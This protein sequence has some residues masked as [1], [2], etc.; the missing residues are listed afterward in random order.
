[1]LRRQRLDARDPRVQ[2]ARLRLLFRLVQPRLD[3]PRYPPLGRQK[4]DL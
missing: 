4:G 2:V 3:D 1:M